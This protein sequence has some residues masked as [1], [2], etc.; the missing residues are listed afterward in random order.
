MKLELCFG[1]NDDLLKVY[2]LIILALV[3]FLRFLN[4]SLY[5]LCGLNYYF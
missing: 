5:C 2:N 3:I 1:F 4:I